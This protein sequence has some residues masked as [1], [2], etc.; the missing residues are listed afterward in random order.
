[1]WLLGL[2]SIFIQRLGIS[3]KN[4]YADATDAQIAG[5]FE[6]LAFFILPSLLVVD[7]IAGLRGSL[8]GATRKASRFQHVSIGWNLYFYTIDTIVVC[9]AKFGV[10]SEKIKAVLP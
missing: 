6:T 2:I 10:F 1:L 9:Q 7:T 8:D 5:I 4:A 3:A